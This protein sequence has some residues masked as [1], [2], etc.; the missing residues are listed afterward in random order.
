MNCSEDRI[1]RVVAE[2]LGVPIERVN[3][4]S[5]VST[6]ENWDSLAHLNMI[7]AI[8][9]EFEISL[10]PEE[11]MQ[12]LSVRLIRLTLEEHGGISSK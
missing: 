3:E 4:D 7:M 2:T 10:T 1:C 9:K 11:A 6:I 5:G 12:I 8:E